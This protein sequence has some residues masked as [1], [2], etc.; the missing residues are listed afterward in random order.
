[1]NN[2]GDATGSFMGFAMPNISEEDVEKFEVMRRDPEI[3]DKIGRS[4]APAIF[5]HPDIKKAIAC[6]LFGPTAIL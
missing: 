1:M 2:E 6:L 4:I 3:Y 5:G